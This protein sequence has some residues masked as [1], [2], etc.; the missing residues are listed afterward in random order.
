[1]TICWS[2]VIKFYRWF[3]VDFW[4][5]SLAH[6]AADVPS[7]IQVGCQVSQNK[8]RASGYVHRPQQEDGAVWWLHCPEQRVLLWPW[9]KGFPQHIQ[10]LQVKKNKI[11][12]SKKK[13]HAWWR[14]R[15]RIPD[16]VYLT[17]SVRTGVLSIKGE[18]CPRNFI[19][20]INYWGVRIKNS[21]RCCRISFEERQ[22]EL[23]EQLKIQ[24]QLLSEVRT[25]PSIT[26]LSFQMFFKLDEHLSS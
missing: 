2:V 19:E 26:F 6:S 13:I 17:V 12:K 7:A 14:Q 10:L 18:L 4:C 22:D 20:E 1:M 8:D 5:W 15:H 9:P 11:N 24:A 25:F 3:K 21:Q 23:N 16:E